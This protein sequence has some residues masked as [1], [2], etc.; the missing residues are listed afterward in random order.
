MKECAYCK[1]TNTEYQGEYGAPGYGQS[2][3][4]NACGKPFDVVG[5]TSVPIPDEPRVFEPWEVE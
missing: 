1:S 5:G 4:C 3:K 2:W